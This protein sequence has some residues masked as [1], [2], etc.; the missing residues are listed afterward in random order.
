MRG[1]LRRLAELLT[2]TGFAVAQPLLDVLGRSGEHFVFRSASAADIVGLTLL[3]TLVPPLALWLLELPV[4]ATSERA[5]RVLHL[6]LLA[7]LAELALIQLLKQVTPLRGLPV[8]VVALVGAGVLVA[9]HERGR[10][11]RLWLVFAAPAPLLFALLFLFTSSVASQVVGREIRVVGATSGTSAS[12]VMLVFDELPLESLITQ[13][14]GIDSQLY[15]NF[16]RL[17]GSSTF[18]NNA[19]TNAWYT[20]HALPALLTGTQ[21]RGDRV[22]TAVDYPRNL[23]S[24]LGSSYRQNV[25][26]VLQL[27]PRRLCGRG[28]ARAPG[29]LRP[30]LTDSVRTWRSMVAPG[31]DTRDVTAEI[32][33]PDAADLAERA[34][35][36]DDADCPA[37][38]CT[39]L[40][41]DQVGRFSTFLA[42]LDGSA[43]RSVNML[44]TLLPHAPWRY[45]PDGTP[46]VAPEPAPGLVKGVWA[47]QYAANVAR[48]RHLLQLRY[49]DRLLGRL[50]DRLHATGLWE[51]SAVVVTADHGVSFQSRHPKREVT[52]HN[53]PDIAWVP[54]LV[55]APGQRA[56][57][58]DDR[59]A[60][61]VDVLPT[62]VEL[63]DLQLPRDWHFDGRSLVGPARPLAEPR[64]MLVSTSRTRA[65]DGVAGLARVRGR[66][67]DTFAGPDPLA[68]R[69]FRRGPQGE[70]VGTR[71]AAYAAGRPVRSRQRLASTA[72][73]PTFVWGT[74]D[75]DPKA[76]GRTYVVAVNGVIGAVGQVFPVGGRAQVAA[77][78]PPHLF[79]AGP[80]L[81]QLYYFG[82][83]PRVVLHPLAR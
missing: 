45:L 81:V 52:D 68:I 29:G 40:R 8:L 7:L 16:A 76:V 5:G 39:Q 71:V 17:A 19:T 33:E 24:L 31:D 20:P 72:D 82:P 83:G 55:K 11:T 36:D 75:R 74:I 35:L 63:L 43:D 44:H 78:L 38:D 12:V 34:A 53:Y 6:A 54:L 37:F 60:Q 9:T 56:P 42:S 69:L 77:V 59:N 64:P 58:T 21:P 79:R 57:R 10:M 26:E 48:Q 66:A 13:N 49:V 47:H 62:L 3:L 61:L 67:V 30:L 2:L 65:L 23:F 32:G 15:P 22:P 27:C 70:L 28:G 73:P 50:I 18:Y 4:A 1:S 80:D 25:H 46:Y 41:H 14:G 51:R